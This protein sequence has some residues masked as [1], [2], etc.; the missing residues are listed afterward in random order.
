LI[1]KRGGKPAMEHKELDFGGDDLK[2]M[3]GKQI[4]LETNGIEKYNKQIQTIRD[5][6]S[7]FRIYVMP[8]FLYQDS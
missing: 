5:L 2:R 3:L 7:H 6:K 4:S 1:T 8:E